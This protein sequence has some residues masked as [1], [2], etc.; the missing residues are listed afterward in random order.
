[1]KSLKIKTF[2][3][4]LLSVVLCVAIM[5]A[6]IITPISVNATSGSW[7]GGEVDRGYRLKIEYREYSKNPKTNTSTVQATLYLVQDPTYSLY[8]GTRTA[9]ITINGIETVISNIPAI[10]NTGGVT[11]KLGSA[12]AM[13]THSPDGSKAIPISATFDMKATLTGTYY[14]T[15]STSQTV[16][17]DQLD[18]TAPKVALTFN[19]STTN[20]VTLTATA[21]TEC[22][23]WQYSRNGG[24]SWITFGSTGKSN[25][26]TISNLS[27]GTSYQVVVRAR[28]TSNNVISEKSSVV[29][30]TTKLKTPDYLTV[31]GITQTKAKFSWRGVTGAKYYKVYLNGILKV[32]GI[33]ETSHTFTALNAN[34]K[35]NFGV[36]AIGNN[37]NSGIA[38]TNYYITLPD[39]PKN[40]QVTNQTTNSVS[41]SWS[42]DNGGN[43]EATRFNIYRDGALIGT[44]STTSYTD[45]TY[46]NTDSSYSVSAVTSAGESAKTSAVLVNH[47]P[48]SIIIST[49]NNST[50][51]TV[52]PAFVGGLNRE[53]DYTSLKWAYG[54]RDCEYFTD[55]GY[56]FTNSFAVLKN[57][58]YTIFAKDTSGNE[59]VRTDEIGSICKEYTQGAFTETFIDL[60]LDC[61]GMPVEIERTYNSM[62]NTDN[63]FGNGWSFNYA[64][65]SYLT[66][67]GSVRVVPLPDG[68]T[69]YF[70]VDGDTYT[71]IGT[72]SKLVEQQIPS[73][74]RLTT[75]DNIKYIYE[76]YYLRRIEDAN[77]NTVIVIDFNA[78]MQPIMI[79]D[80][81][82]RSFT[83]S[84]TNNKISRIGVFGILGCSYIYD[85][86]GNL[87]EQRLSNGIVVNK[88]SYTNGLLTKITDE[89][90]NT[91]CEIVYNSENQMVN[92]T[93]ADGSTTYYLYKVTNNGETVIYESD[94]EI[95]LDE[96]DCTTHPASNTYNSL[97]QIILDA[98]GFLYE[99]NANGTI[100]KIDGVNSDKTLV[101]Y[102]YDEYGNVIHIETTDKDD[103]LIEDVTYNYTYF[104]GSEKIAS[105]T[106]VL[107]TNTYNEDG[108]IAETDIQTIIS[109]YD[110]VG[111]LLSE[112][113]IHNEI[114]KTVTYTY[115]SR[116]EILETT[117]DGKTTYYTYDRYGN[118]ESIRIFENNESTQIE[119]VQYTYNIINQVLTQIKDGL[120]TTYIYDLIGNA[121]KV[122]QSDGS[123]TRVSRVVYDNNSRVVQKISDQQYNEAD[124]GLNPDNNGICSTNIYNNSN[125]GERYTYDTKGNVLT[126]I[127]KADNKTVNTY[128][129]ENRLVKTV[130]YENAST[131][132]NGL[133]TRYVY[134]ADGNLIQTV[135]PHQYN[136]ENDNLD[137]SNDV[138]EYT[139]DTIGERVTYDENGN[140]LTH[141]DSF[142]K[143]IVNIYDSKNH[144]VK[145]V[146]GNE[147]T[148]F[149]YN[150][151]DN[152]LQVIYPNQYNPD[153]DNLNLSAE[154]PVDT[155]AN[156]NVGDRYTY[157][158][159]GNILTYTNQY[160]EVT[161]NTYDADG[162]L[163][164]TTKPDGTVF[165]FDKED[166]VTRE[167]Y[168]NGLTRDYTHNTNQTIIAGSNGI[169][170]TYNL[171]SFGEITE[172]K[173]Q[174][175]ENNKYYSYT[176]D[177]DGNIT[178]ISLNG[179]LQQTFTYNSSN[180]LVRVDDAV[181]NK[182]ITY[183]YDY[184]GNITSVKT[185]LYT[186]GT[187]G[188]PLTTQ[189]YTYNSQNQR[190]DLSYDANGNMTS[191]NGYTFGWTNRRL[192]SATSTDNSISYT[193]N[194]NGIRTSKTINGIT[195]YYVV[196]EN[197]NVV[198]QYELE[199][200]VETN[201]IEFVYDSNGSP[202]Y[203]TYNNATYYYEK[204]L[205]GDIVAILDANGNTVVEY[206]YDI[207]GKL[208]G[209]TGSLADTIGTI[210]PL[211]YRGY[212]YDT[213]TNLY[214]LQSRYYSPDLMRFI[215]QDDAALS[216]EQGQPLG[217][218]LYAY[219]L[220]NPVIKVDP[221]GKEPITL[222][223][224]GIYFLAT[225]FVTIVVSAIVTSPEFIRSWNSMCTSIG[226]GISS[227]L[228][229]LGGAIK[230]AASKLSSK[231]KSIA[232]SIGNSFAR[233]KSIPKYRSPREVHH[234]VAQ[235]ASN[236]SYAR[237]ILKKVGIGYNSSYNLVSIKTGLHRRL[238]TNEYY[239]WAN[240]VVISA[241]NS[242]KGNKAKQ[243]S[244]VI[245]ALNTIRAY[246]L[247]MDASSPY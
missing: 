200:D 55:N 236:A 28:K 54:I 39:T 181:V 90:N 141:I 193:Y 187:L 171:N 117:A 210:N 104:T 229:A 173:L 142:G 118:T 83:I 53:V 80:S 64:K 185:Y 78:N 158:D 175:G 59:T 9:T 238:H 127:N 128:D 232:K 46:G 23:N 69:E 183:D 34:T 73:E 235:K 105:I 65:S 11:T 191:L 4:P 203:F 56:T 131:T 60:S 21:N 115:N 30:A 111:Q 71:G 99:Y 57:G 204:N 18:R 77:G 163:T 224:I 218:N 220:N 114:D 35:Y 74:L 130:T 52:T 219:C 47:V 129:S 190:T 82:G 19:S 167:V 6:T 199:N 62:G 50:Y 63:L 228:N 194:H 94:S 16:V 177:S 5:L 165:T 110:N 68:T 231:A 243:R 67:D 133:T 155:Y 135:Y 197:N 61:V 147:T 123:I 244:N 144:L 72:Q 166:K 227:G 58:T 189:N 137:V 156:A 122:T 242:A 201:V 10:Q 237:N 13:V 174:N 164:S 216:N 49:T 245:G 196:D 12:V 108:N 41:L 157:D 180:E 140:I 169:T 98:E 209:I 2:F 93:D 87:I 184:V 159:N 17:L 40:L 38:T 3:K 1:M 221:T 86:D 233:A 92:Y 162:G 240:S 178:T 101:V 121:I 195:T 213:E 48:L 97:D 146:S 125:V 149:V 102:T 212:Y 161:T 106:E 124:D 207:W 89:L 234:I 202:I 42:Q 85:D 170:I 70:R 132:A 31:S 247:L 116:G 100:H 208:L 66:D 186:T 223:A 148:R 20:S 222:T 103:R 112:R 27:S 152:L 22:D 76:N 215:S 176:Y 151:G 37:D 198:K 81:I 230:S 246:V 214:Y 45:A 143:E 134:D 107:V 14:G 145:S 241:Y 182:T 36:C 109:M 217:S 188:T 8:I 138:N 96:T 225:A 179:S 15:M 211:R 33:T 88:F 75:K 168:S 84:Y 226:Y 25:T 120:T 205:Q 113:T 51:A 26:F 150:G 172:Y 160:G 91:I 154:T 119:E 153:D 136:A 24:S 32:G 206:T 44:S 79:T 139:D 29:I 7:T 95:V 239:G 126:Y 192:T 43:A